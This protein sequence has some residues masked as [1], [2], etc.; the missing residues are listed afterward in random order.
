MAEEWKITYRSELGRHVTF[1]RQ[2]IPWA[3]PTTATATPEAAWEAWINLRGGLMA[4]SVSLVL[5]EVTADGSTARELIVGMVEMNHLPLVG[6][7]VKPP[8]SKD[9]YRLLD[10][11][12]IAGVDR[13]GEEN[14]LLYLDAS[15]RIY[16][17]ASDR[18]T[19]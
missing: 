8:A 18:R 11:L 14:V 16:L 17:D 3:L 1:R 10:R 4:F 19:D 6:D 12:W 5:N 7:Y 9:A 13:N 15:D 2:D